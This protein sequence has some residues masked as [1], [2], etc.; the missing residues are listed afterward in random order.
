MAKSITS[1]NAV[2]YLAVVGIAVVPVQIKEFAADD[3]FS[4]DPVEPAEVLM[5]V[6]G[7][8]SAGFVY[9]PRKQA[10][11]LQG[12]SPSADFFD[13]WELA[14]I[15]A[16]DQ[17]F[18]NGTLLLPSIGK[19]WAM[20]GGALTTFSQIPDSGKT[21]RPRRYGLTWERVYPMPA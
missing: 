16:G 6:D 5:G 3:I 7:V 18:A 8:M 12:N 21:I 20:T 1:S 11:T 17:F 19:K 10:I 4:M 15:T 14:Q 13:N 2:L 9:V